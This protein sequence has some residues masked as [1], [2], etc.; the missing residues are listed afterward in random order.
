MKFSPLPCY[1]VPRRPKYYPQHHILTLRQE[2]CY[3]IDKCTTREEESTELLEAFR[4]I[5]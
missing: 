5:I 1:L 4:F 3:T 2:A